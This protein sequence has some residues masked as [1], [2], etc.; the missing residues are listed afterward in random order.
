MNVYEFNINNVKS[1]NLTDPIG[2]HIQIA[3]SE[4]NRKK[5][6]EVDEVKRSVSNKIYF[7]IESS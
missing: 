7:L 1:P 4:E 3:E 6:T 2:F 5:I